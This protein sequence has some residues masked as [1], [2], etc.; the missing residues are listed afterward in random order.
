LR[1]NQFTSDRNGG[2]NTKGRSLEAARENEGNRGKEDGTSSTACAAI[3]QTGEDV[4]QFLCGDSQICGADERVYRERRVSRSSCQ[5]KA[6]PT[7]NTP[8]ANLPQTNTAASEHTR[9]SER[10]RYGGE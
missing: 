10:V 4:W 7:I 6:I 1:D 2:K 3:L 9:E 8:S 5:H